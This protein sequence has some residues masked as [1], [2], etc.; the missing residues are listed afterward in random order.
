MAEV[1]T[2]VSYI[3]TRHGPAS[4]TCGLLIYSASSAHCPRPIRQLVDFSTR[5]R[6][7]TNELPAPKAPT[8]DRPVFQETNTLFYPLR[9]PTSKHI[10]W[11]LLF[12][13]FKKMKR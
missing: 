4:D 8:D 12:M 3:V 6:H 1:Y 9:I 7:E 5:K 10:L 13:N 2:T 11:K